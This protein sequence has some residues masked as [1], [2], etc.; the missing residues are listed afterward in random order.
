MR[1]LALPP[2]ALRDD[3]CVPPFPTPPSRVYAGFWI[4]VGALFIDGLVLFVPSNAITVITGL[5][6]DA[7]GESGA[8]VAILV[9]MV[10][11]IALWWGYSAVM[12]SSAWQGT[13]GK[14]AVGLIVV[15]AHGGRLSLARATGR[16]FATWLSDLT[17]G[18]GYMMAG[19]TPRKRA[20]HDYIADTYVVRRREYGAWR[21]TQPT[22]ASELDTLPAPV[23]LT[24]EA[25]RIAADL[26]ARI[27]ALV[28]QPQALATAPHATL[29]AEARAAAEAL[30][31]AAIGSPEA[32]AA[33][34]L[35]HCAHAFSALAQA[36]TAAQATDYLRELVD[37][38]VGDATFRAWVQTHRTTRTA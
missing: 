21:E 7:A 32:S 28:R 19:W 34:T 27:A 13:V 12:T 10:A 18:I 24:P 4:R 15:D 25:R 37:W 33:T 8:L 31:G 11:H 26:C 23:A 6:E 16:H 5:W 30:S 9:D 17:L 1:K 36:D 22:G 2:P 20:L 29:A 38:M 3:G 35:G 14:H